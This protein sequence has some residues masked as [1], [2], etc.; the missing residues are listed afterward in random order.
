MATKQLRAWFF[1][2]PELSTYGRF[3]RYNKPTKETFE[4]LLASVPFFEEENSRATEVMHGLARLATDKEI[5]DRE[6]VAAMAQPH[7][8]PEVI[9]GVGMKLGEIDQITSHEVFKVDFAPGSLA[10]E[11]AEAVN[12]LVGVFGGVPKKIALGSISG[13]NYFVKEGTVIKLADPGDELLVEGNI[14]AENFYLTGTSG[15]RRIKP[16]NVPDAV[17]MAVDISGGGSVSDGNYAGGDVFIHGG[18]PSG[19]GSYGNSLIGYDGNAARGLVGIRGGHDGTGVFQTKIHDNV[20]ITGKVKAGLSGNVI[21]VTNAIGE[22]AAGGISLEELGNLAGSASNIQ[23]QIITL[24]Q[25]VSMV[26]GN[27]TTL[28]GRIGAVESALST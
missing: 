22:F 13:A 15:I 24:L 7:Q 20:W 23:T 5:L 27:L 26:S 28:E 6:D 2:T 12:Y 19:T 4:D 11:G 17:G 9:A 10:I 25:E 8:L 16:V 21:V 3:S 14:T 18:T 1:E